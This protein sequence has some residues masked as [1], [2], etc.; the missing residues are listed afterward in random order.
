ML[1]G[2][3]NHIQIVGQ[4]LGHCH[5][6]GSGNAGNRGFQLNLEARRRPLVPHFGQADYPG[7]KTT[8]EARSFLWIVILEILRVE[9]VV[10]ELVSFEEDVV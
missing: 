4:R 3:Q 1:S 8:G 6:T 7:W 9:L 2:R 10:E 5:C